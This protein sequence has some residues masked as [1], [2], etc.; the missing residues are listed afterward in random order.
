MPARDYGSRRLKDHNPDIG[1]PHDAIIEGRAEAPAPAPEIQPEPEPPAQKPTPIL[2]VPPPTF[3][4]PPVENNDSI[5][6]DS[7]IKVLLT[8]MPPDVSE[9]V[10][11]YHT[12]YGV[13]LWQAVAGYIMRS[14]EEGTLMSPIILPDWAEMVSPSAPRPCLTCGGM[15]NRRIWSQEYC[16]SA[17]H[18]GKIHIHGHTTA[19]VLITTGMLATTA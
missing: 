16:C 4:R 7:A 11:E 14:R 17:C 18:F 13:P 10:M 19:C 3:N 2:L 15:M 1:G 8:Y 6:M 5:I 12:T 9:L